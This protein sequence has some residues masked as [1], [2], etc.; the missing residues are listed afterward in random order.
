MS[1]SP[2][3]KGDT[4]A[5]T[6]WT[7][8]TWTEYKQNVEAFAKSLISI[9]FEKFDAVN[10]LGFNAPQWHFANFGAIF[11]GGISA[12]IYVT[13]GP[14]ACKYTSEH[15]EAKVVVVEGVKQLEKY[16]SIAKDLPKLKA[17]VVYG[18]DSI[19]ADVKD[20]VSIPVYKFDDFSKLG[21]SVS[22]ADLQARKDAQLPNEVTT[23]IYTSGT[24]GPPKA[25]MLT[26]DNITW[27]AQSQFSTMPNLDNDDLMVSYLP[28]S[29]IAAQMLDMHGPLLSGYQVWFAQPDALKG[30]LGATLKE[31]R[32]TLFLGVPRVWEKIYDKMQEV[33]K[34]TTGVKKVLSTWAKGEAAQH[35]KAN[36]Y[37]SEESEPWFYSL[38]KVLLGKVREAL[39]LD[40]VS[41]N[42]VLKYISVIKKRILIHR[43]F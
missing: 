19:P 26:H 11:A 4:A 40:R 37:E 21:E 9:G 30:S 20:K 18:P 17:L 42:S 16:Y 35:W 43:S 41:I 7:T 14:D 33:G 10:V 28:L 32:P 36:Q 22:D 1:C 24:T 23:L 5:G 15:S 6:P 13:N 2:S 38:A 27:T 3:P 31:V 29:H 12:G 8:W 25:A 34:S 39:G